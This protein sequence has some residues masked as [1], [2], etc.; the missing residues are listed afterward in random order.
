MDYE[1]GIPTTAKKRRLIFGTALLLA[2]FFIIL[3]VF[4]VILAKFLPYLGGK[5][6]AVVDI[7]MPLS[8]EGSPTTLVNPGYPSS[9]QLAN[10]IRELNERDDVA[11]VLFVFNSGGG[12]VVATHEIYN[13][14]KELKKPKVS[15]FREVAASGAYY[16]A[17]G[18]DYIISDPAALTGNI[19]AVATT[20][21]ISGLLDKVGINATSITSGAHKDIGSPYRNMTEEEYTILKSIVDEISDEFK[22][23][24]IQNRKEKLDYAK[25]NEIMDGRIM[26]GRQALAVGLVD[27]LGDKNDAIM[28]AAELGGL[29]VEKPEDVKICYV[30]VA[31]QEGG[32]LNLESF[33]NSV[34]E[35]F[36]FTSL[37][38]Q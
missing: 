18:T 20:V 26:T 4:F 14:V 16:V 30:S 27:E 31:P 37:K 9:E 2:L 10:S 22:T 25:F 32:I 34:N 3:V 23:I 5:C 38:F 28:K 11:A 36:H 19:G 13:A 7:N 21:S 24:I 29:K 15:Y 17:A 35:K 1:K 6:V 33:V 8:V 12:S